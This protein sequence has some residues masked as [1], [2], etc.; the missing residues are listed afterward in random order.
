MGVISIIKLE[1]RYFLVQ[2]GLMWLSCEGQS[3]AVEGRGPGRCRSSF[4][5]HL[6]CSQ[7]PNQNTDHILKYFP[8]LIECFPI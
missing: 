6:H 5:G 3:E 1:L 4:A 7:I 8:L 2:K